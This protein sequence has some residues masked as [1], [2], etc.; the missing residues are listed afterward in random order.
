MSSIR[1][2]ALA[3]AAGSVGEALIPE[4]VA[5]GFEVTALI[6][7]G[8][9]STL[10][11]SVKTVTVDFSDVSALTDALTGFDALISTVGSPGIQSQTYMVDAA[12]AAKVK[13]FIPSEFGSDMSNA[14]A[15]SLPVYKL[16]VEVE[17]YIENALKGS[18]TSYTPVYNSAFLDWGIQRKLLIDI[19]GKKMEMFD[20]GEK[21]YT[22]APLSFVAKGVVG[23]LQHPEETANR[24]VRLH[25]TS[26]TQKKLLEIAQRVVGKDGWEVV[27]R[28]SEETEKQSYERLKKDPGNVMGWAIGFLTRSIYGE[29]F[30]S[31]FSGKNDNELLGLKELNEKEVEEVVKGCV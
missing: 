3:G 16:K 19:E 6:R 8:S 11:S 28:S 22:A 4:L 15:R 1:K 2:V 14:R 29:E 20:G 23:I 21:P 18:E 7:P 25:G 30:G 31:D 12:V 26:I 9:T 13:R 24:A 5:S 27:E 10:P 17:E